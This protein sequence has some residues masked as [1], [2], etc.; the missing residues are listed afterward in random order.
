MKNPRSCKLPNILPPIQAVHVPSHHSTLGLRVRH[1]PVPGL[2]VAPVQLHE[3][4]SEDTQR[5]SV[6]EGEDETAREGTGETRNSRTQAREAERITGSQTGILRA[7]KKL[8]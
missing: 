1:L 7:P 5:M 6:G 4:P 3:A 8:D 2:H